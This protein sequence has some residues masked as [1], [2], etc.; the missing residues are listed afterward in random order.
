MEAGGGQRARPRRW[1]GTNVVVVWKVRDRRVRLRFSVAVVAHASVW[2]SASGVR[3]QCLVVVAVE[4]R[5]AWREQHH[6]QHMLEDT[7][8]WFVPVSHF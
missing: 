2:V 1:G 4:W 5:V 7:N 3:Y 8:V 6:E